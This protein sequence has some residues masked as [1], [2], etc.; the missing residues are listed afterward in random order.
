MPEI[1]FARPTA[2]ATASHG[3]AGEE[4]DSGASA[5]RPRRPRPR[6]PPAS[7]PAAAPP[8]HLLAFASTPPRAPHALPVSGLRLLRRRVG[9]RPLRGLLAPL[10]PYLQGDLQG[11]ELHRQ[12]QG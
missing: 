6:P 5:A 10:R 1:C 11:M 12:W 8:P 9:A 7:A 2:P 3:T 4:P